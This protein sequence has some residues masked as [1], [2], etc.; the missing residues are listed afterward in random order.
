MVVDTSMVEQPTHPGYERNNALVHLAHNALFELWVD[1]GD[2]RG[3]GILVV[4]VCPLVL[5]IADRSLYR[6]RH[7]GGCRGVKTEWIC[8]S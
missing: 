5:F 7:G 6:R 8:I 4:K 3:V 2:R 1:L